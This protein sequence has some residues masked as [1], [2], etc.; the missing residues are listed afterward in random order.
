MTP[1]VIVSHTSKRRFV[2]TL[3]GTPLWSAGPSKEYAVG[4]LLLTFGWR[5]GVAVLVERTHESGFC[6]VPLL[7]VVRV[8]RVVTPIED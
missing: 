6:A 5:M 3:V 2:A 4:A 7:P 8:T 1:L